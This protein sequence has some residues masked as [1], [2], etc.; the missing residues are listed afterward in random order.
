MKLYLH[1]L[2]TSFTADA[3]IFQSV[4]N[5]TFF[6]DQF[7]AYF[8]SVQFMAY[9][10]VCTFIRLTV[11]IGIDDRSCL[12]LVTAEPQLLFELIFGSEYNRRQRLSA[13]ITVKLKLK[14]VH[15]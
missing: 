4:I 5:S 9:L 10:I 2:G 8:A 6:A 14:T 3:A 12:P 1:F 11:I 13:A 7:T 15:R